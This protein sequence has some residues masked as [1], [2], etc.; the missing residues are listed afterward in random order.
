MVNGQ[1]HLFVLQ[2]V[3]TTRFNQAPSVKHTLSAYLT[4]YMSGQGASKRTDWGPKSWGALLS[5]Q[6]EME[7]I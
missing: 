3:G 5:M 7:I 1:L 2:W 4:T 6:G